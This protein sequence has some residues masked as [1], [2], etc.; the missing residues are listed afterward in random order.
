MIFGTNLLTQSPVPVSVFYLV[1][2]YRRKG[3]P[4]GVQLTCHLTKIIFGPEEA[5]EVPEA[6]QKSPGMPTRAGACLPASWLPRCFPYI[7]S[8]SPGL[9]LFQK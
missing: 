2:E 4:Y 7:H 5:H 6:G 9:L 8:K 3:K 1:L